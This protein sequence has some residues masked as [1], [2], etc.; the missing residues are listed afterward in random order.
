MGLGGCGEH[1][2][3]VPVGFGGAPAGFGVGSVG[4]GGV[5]MGPGGFG[6]VVTLWGAPPP[7]PQPAADLAF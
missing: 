1:L 4:L 6:G 2:E 3:K 5:S 7:E